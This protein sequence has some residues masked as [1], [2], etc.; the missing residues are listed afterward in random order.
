MKSHLIDGCGLDRAAELIVPD[1]AVGLVPDSDFAHTFRN[2]HPDLSDFLPYAY[3]THHPDIEIKTG[4][5]DDY[6][7]QRC[8]SVVLIQLRIVA[9]RVQIPLQLL[10]RLDEES[11]GVR[12]RRGGNSR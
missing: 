11:G 10:E 3:Y 1:D 12:L 4:F 9:P 2:I 8:L 5:R 6:L 7:D